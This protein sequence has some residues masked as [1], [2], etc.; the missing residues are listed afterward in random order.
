MHAVLPQQCLWW[1]RSHTLRVSAKR[2]CHY[3]YCQAGQNSRKGSWGD[4]AVASPE[5]AVVSVRCGAPWQGLPRGA[6]KHS[7]PSSLSPARWMKAGDLILALFWYTD[8]H[9]SPTSVDCFPLG[10]QAQ[11]WT[12]STSLINNALLL[13]GAFNWGKI[14][15]ISQESIPSFSPSLPLSPSGNDAFA[16][17]SNTIQ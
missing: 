1:E 15:H 11:R 6:L 3:G 8:E 2:Q 4:S 9:E 5:M 13:T 14:C 16:S 17:L 12:R 7:L 10:A